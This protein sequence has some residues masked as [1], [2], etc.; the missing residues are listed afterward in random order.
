MYEILPLPE[1]AR[2]LFAQIEEKGGAVS[3]LGKHS[4]NDDGI[5]SVLQFVIF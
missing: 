5:Y 2:I 3:S 1:R 4:Q